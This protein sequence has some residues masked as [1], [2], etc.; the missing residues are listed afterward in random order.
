MCSIVMFAAF[1]G[2]LVTIYYC[3]RFIWELI[4]ISNISGR[5]VFITGCDS[6]FG[7]RICLKC[8][9]NGMTVFAGCFSEKG[10][11]SLVA[12]AK[13]LAGTLDVIHLDVTSDRSV[14][15][16]YEYVENKLKDGKQ[17]W[18]ILNNA[19][20]FVY[21]PED[22]CTLDDYKLAID[23][24]TLG[25]IRITHAFKRLLKQ[26]KG[27]IVT[28]A[29]VAGRTAMPASGPY[30]VSKFAVEAFMD[31]VRQE[32]RDFGIQCSIIEPGIFAT[33]M[34]DKGILSKR[35]HTMWERLDDESKAEYGEDFLENY[36]KNFLMNPRL[37]KSENLDWVINSYY[38]ALTAIFPRNRYRC[39]WDAIFFYIPQCF[40]PTEIT[41]LL[42]RTALKSIM[43]K[44]AALIDKKNR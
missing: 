27:R 9:K 32:L 29:S 22:W 14:Q 21:G 26:S 17:L 28:M 10:G 4:P 1:C 12:E 2:I 38:H 42:N 31:I 19:G 33:E 34:A 16:A 30:T 8:L 5:I 43:P 7:R 18:A 39:G 35:M 11:A 20:I 44:P 37:F 3:L 13:H 36:R 40:F 23:V 15:E 6:G 24:N 25:V 41:D